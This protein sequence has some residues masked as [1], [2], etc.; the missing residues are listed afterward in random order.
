MN[1]ADLTTTPTIL[2]CPPDHYGIEYEIN[3][4]MDRR[5]QAD[6]E[7]AKRQ[8][9]DLNHALSHCALA[10]GTPNRIAVLS[11]RHGEIAPLSGP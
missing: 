10:G 8:W 7:L 1:R 5:R 11:H 6:A 3:A 9:N 4:W 2:M